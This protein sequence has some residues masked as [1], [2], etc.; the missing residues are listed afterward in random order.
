VAKRKEHRHRVYVPVP[1]GA[2]RLSG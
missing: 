2:P 1:S